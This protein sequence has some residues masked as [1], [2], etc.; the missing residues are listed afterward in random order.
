MCHYHTK[1]R[2]RHDCENHRKLR[3]ERASRIAKETK[4]AEETKEV[5]DTKETLTSIP[6]VYSHT[7]QETSHITQGPSQTSHVSVASHTATPSH[8]TQE[9]AK[10][11][12]CSQT[13]FA[14]QEAIT[15]KLTALISLIKKNINKLDKVPEEFNSKEAMVIMCTSPLQRAVDDL[16]RKKITIDQAIQIYRKESSYLIQKYGVTM[17]F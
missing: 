2:M 5:K 16:K 11:P 7:T 1:E 4:E 15:K 9:K 10:A 8:V 12:L 14:V 17:K 3:L 6:V 13:S